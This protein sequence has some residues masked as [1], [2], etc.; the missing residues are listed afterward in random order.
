M[1][2]LIISISL[3]AAAHATIMLYRRYNQEE[4]TTL[5]MLRRLRYE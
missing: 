3:L 5:E 2:W 1:K 4:L